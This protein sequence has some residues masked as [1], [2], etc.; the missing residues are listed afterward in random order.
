MTK[1]PHFFEKFGF[2]FYKS[3]KISLLKKILDL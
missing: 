1:N 2:V 3:D